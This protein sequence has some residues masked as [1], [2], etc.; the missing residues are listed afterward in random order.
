MTWH[1]GVNPIKWSNDDFRDLGGDTPLETCLKEARDAGYEGIELG[2]KMERRADVLKPVL[3]RYGLRLISGWH[4]TYI[5]ENDLKKEEDSFAKHL[6]F[7][8]AMGCDVA[9][10]AECSQRNYHD[11]SLRMVHHAGAKLLTDAQWDRLAKGLE[12][13]AMV[14]ESEGLKPA[15]HHHMGT[16]VQDGEQL[17]ALMDRTSKLGL[18][19]DSGHMAYGGM[20]PIE[21]FQRYANR[22]FHVHFKDVRSAIVQKAVAQNL[23]FSE[24]VRAGVFTVPGDGDLDFAALTA[25][26]KK[27]NYQ[28]WIVVE[29][30]QDPK[31][32]N[33]FIYAK[34]GR[35]HLRALI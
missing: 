27:A 34:K 32:A 23:T 9:I 33:P 19:A 26:L 24:A 2:H 3:D 21:T 22:I 25:I 35:E 5:L 20:D 17:A 1:I 6:R 16:V 28:G 12:R 30:E 18:T 31:K 14:C 4:S 15:Y 13:L 7:L 11:A 10:L 8:K 29:A